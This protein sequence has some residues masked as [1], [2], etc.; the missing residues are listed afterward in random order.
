MCARVRTR[1]RVHGLYQVKRVKHHT[2]IM[3]NDDS[4]NNYIHANKQIEANTN[5]LCGNVR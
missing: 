3:V 1:A 4:N 2:N 5:F